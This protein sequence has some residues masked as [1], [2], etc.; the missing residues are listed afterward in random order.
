MSLR[1]RANPVRIAIRVDASAYIGTGHLHRSL[2]LAHALLALGSEVRFVTRSLGIDSLGMIAGAGFDHTVLLGRPGSAFTPDPQVPHS[3]WAQVSCEQDVAETIEALSSFAPDW[4]VLDS[5]AFD[6]K[7]HEDVRA[8]LEC[9]IAQIDDLADR[10]LACDLLIDH[11]YAGDHRAKYA[12]VLPLAATLLGGPKYGLLGPV[13]AQAQRYKFHESVRSIGV[14]MGGVDAGGHSMVVLDALDAIGF[15]GA[16]EI[17]ST[18]ANLHLGDLRERLARRANA[19][20]SLNLPDLAAFFARHDLQVGAGGGA[21]WERCCIGVP[22]L[23]LVIAENQLSVAPQLAA[24]GV[25]AL[26]P[27]P[28]SEAIAHELANLIVSPDKRRLLA[29]RSRALVDGKGATR[30]AREFQCIA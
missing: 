28:T 19:T 30:V 22:T 14:F 29:S 3:Y 1:Q 23:L 26:A 27:Q 18:S 2:A 25:V 7:W 13:F 17:V 6:A 16:V 12:A 4:V 15:E 21:S 10:K 24:D 5:Y 20:L 8:G 9:R 11:T